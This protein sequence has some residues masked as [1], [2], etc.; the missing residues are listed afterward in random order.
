MSNQHN[1]ELAGPH[2]KDQPA[3]EPA[4]ETPIQTD[5]SGTNPQLAAND[6]TISSNQS[7]RPEISGKNADSET[8]RVHPALG[9]KNIVI[10]GEYVEKLEREL[11]ASK[12]QIENALMLADKREKERDEARRQAEL[13]KLASNVAGGICSHAYKERD[14]AEKQLAAA[15][16]ALE[17]IYMNYDLASCRILARDTLA[18]IDGEQP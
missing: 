3:Q 4:S 18:S 15:R 9:G 1:S 10:N 7:Q 2:S 13:S 6:A 14:N 5:K 8:P 17:K 16:E 12:T 11:A